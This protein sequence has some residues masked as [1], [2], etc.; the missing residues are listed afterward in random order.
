MGAV[1]QVRQVH[2][3]RLAALKI[4]PPELSK[5]PG[6][7]ER[8]LR[9]ARALARLNHPHVVAVYD[10]GQAGEWPYILME[11]VDGANLRQV[12]A[13]GSLGA[14]EALAL[15]PPLCEA[16]Q[17]A[18]DEGIVHRDIKPENILLD[19]KGRVKITDFGLAKLKR[20][21]PGEYSLTGSQSMV[22]TPQYMAPEQIE[23]AREVDHRSDIY[24]LGVVLYEMLTGE[25][26]L[27]RFE[28]PSRR[29]QIDVRLDEVV[30]KALEKDPRQRYQQAGEMATAFEKIAGEEGKEKA[31]GAQTGPGQDR[32]TQKDPKVKGDPCSPRQSPQW[33][34][35][36]WQVD[37]GKGEIRI[38]N[39]ILIKPGHIRIGAMELG[40]SRKE[41]EKERAHSK[42]R[43]KKTKV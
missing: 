43:A 40:E 38:G 5:E 20:P 41:R 15:V 26:P 10:F 6:F 29:V 18:H 8:F 16:L 37:E 25:L 21:G 31:F 7:L 3:D 1:Y 4:L 33:K 34:K 39:S 30:L 12:Q 14:R 9:E 36:N 13:S 24:S 27:G 19:R 23:R 2:L 32:S 28:P 11:Y 22:G 17:F 35:G 42:K